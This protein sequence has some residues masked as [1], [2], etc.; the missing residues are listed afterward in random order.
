MQLINFCQNM[1]QIQW[2][3]T[4][5]NPQEY[6]FTEN[7]LAGADSSLHEVIIQYKNNKRTECDTAQ[8]EVAVK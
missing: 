1:L 3:R 4:R 5:R 2:T 6:S 7:S 8:N